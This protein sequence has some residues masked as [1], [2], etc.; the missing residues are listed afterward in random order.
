MSGTAYSDY[1][2]TAVVGYENHDEYIET[3]RTVV[4]VVGSADIF[5]MGDAEHAAFDMILTPRDYNGWF[6]IESIVRVPSA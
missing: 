3:G 4:R 2:V 5:T 1:I 6:R